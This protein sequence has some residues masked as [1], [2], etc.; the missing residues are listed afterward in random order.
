MNRLYDFYVELEPY[1]L[2]RFLCSLTSHEFTWTFIPV[3]R[4]WLAFRLVIVFLNI[5]FL[6]DIKYDACRIS[7]TC[8]SHLVNGILMCYVLI[9]RNTVW[10]QAFL[11]SKLERCAHGNLESRPM[12]FLESA[13]FMKSFRFGI[14]TMP[15]NSYHKKVHHGEHTGTA[16]V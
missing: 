13:P 16:S 9:Y 3:P 7:C 8:A 12:L 1:D 4:Q 6:Q 14:F 2:L 10:L 15:F 5:Y 11:K